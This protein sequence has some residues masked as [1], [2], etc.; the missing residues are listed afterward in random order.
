MKK[1]IIIMLFI[2][3]FVLVSCDDGEEVNPGVEVISAPTFDQD[4]N[5][6]GGSDDPTPPPGG[7]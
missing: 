1:M 5:S 7:G 3:P 4:G 6:G 2:S